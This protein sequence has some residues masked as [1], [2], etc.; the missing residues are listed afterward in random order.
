[1]R[2]DGCASVGMGPDGLTLFRGDCLD[3]LLDRCGLCRDLPSGTA[4]RILA[5]F[6]LCWPPV[7]ILSFLQGFA[8]GPTMRTSFLFDLAA[9]GQ[10]FLGIPLMLAAEPIVE[11]QIISAGLHFVASGL[12]PGSSAKRC[13][14]SIEM[15][16]KMAR[17]RWTTGFCLI[18]AY[19]LTWLWLGRELQGDWE[20]W[21]A[22]GTDA[23]KSLTM[24]GA[25]AG[26]IAVPI[27]NFVWLRWLCKIATWI[28]FLRRMS[29][30]PLRLVAGH[31]D[32]MGGLGFLSS[33]QT[34]FGLLIFS[35]GAVIGTNFI[36]RATVSPSPFWEFASWGPVV[37]FAIGAPG[38]FLVPLTLF[39]RKLQDL[40]MAAALDID[41]IIQLRLEGLD[42]E[43]VQCDGPAVE[44]H[45]QLRRRFSVARRFADEY[46]Q[47]RKLRVVPF[48]LRSVAQL[49]GT[50]VLPMLPIV[51][52]IISMPHLLNKFFERFG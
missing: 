10:F 24:A 46:E 31:P 36:Y 38:A 52:E 15:A 51:P 23:R 2:L 28:W 32:R 22:T 30:I 50:A 1:M 8:L 12:V 34:S 48:D 27:F 33:V 6:L 21:H 39:T 35:F 17:S 19:G 3:R 45:K 43:S 20:T 9:Y 25:W 47:V 14:E 16:G 5:L 13:A 7:L 18:V 29:A 42:E 49:F 41:S 37:G 40:K 26:I 44:L 11:R 4:R